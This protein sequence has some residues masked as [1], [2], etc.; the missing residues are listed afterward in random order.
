MSDDSSAIADGP[1]AEECEESV[2]AVGGESTHARQQGE[3]K[4]HDISQPNA[5]LNDELASWAGICQLTWRQQQ[6]KL[7]EEALH[8]R[9]RDTC[10]EGGVSDKRCVSLVTR[11]YNEVEGCDSIEK[12]VTLCTK[13]WTRPPR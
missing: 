9:Y 4:T 1:Q 2:E 10:E 12:M 8:E 6:L 13:H 5:T 3:K 7:R 11:G